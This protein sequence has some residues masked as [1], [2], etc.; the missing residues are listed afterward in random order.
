[1]KINFA[2]RIYKKGLE[3]TKVELHIKMSA[4]RINHY[5]IVQHMLHRYEKY[6]QIATK[7]KRPYKINIKTLSVEDAQKIY[8]YISIP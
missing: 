6:V 4:G 5:R 3:R 1:M 8:D 7:G 2:P